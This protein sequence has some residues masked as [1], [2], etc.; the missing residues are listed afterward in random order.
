MKVLDLKVNHIKNPLGY[1]VDKPTFTWRVEGAKGKFQKEAQVKVSKDK[2]FKD[3]VYDS[4]KSAQISSLG[5]TPEMNL[6]AR[7]RYY[8][9]VEVWDDFDNHGI[10]DVEWFETGKI[11]EEWVGK[12][13]TTPFEKMFIH[14]LLR[15]YI[16][17]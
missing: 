11:D 17:R 13:V 1:M 4:K 5:F 9:K 3:I 7:T 8:W 12:W 15:A 10:S 14:T 6:E 2:D 16:F